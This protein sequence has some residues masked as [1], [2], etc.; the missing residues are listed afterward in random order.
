[1]G[2][3]YQQ[4]G[5]RVDDEESAPQSAECQRPP[6]VLPFKAEAKRVF[7]FSPGKLISILQLCC[8]GER[9]IQTTTD[10][11][12]ASD[13]HDR[14]LRVRSVR[15]SLAARRVDHGFQTNL[16][17]RVRKFV[18]SILKDALEGSSGLIHQR[19]IE[20]RSNAQY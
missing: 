4:V 19:W 8:W 10:I 11:E 14:R 9:W 20:Y 7:S 5:E 12:G 17:R 15:C 13:I 18:G 2:S 6:H 3:T 16:L 1:T